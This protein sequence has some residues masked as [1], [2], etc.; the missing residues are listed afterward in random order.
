MHNRLSSINNYNNN[1]RDQYYDMYFM[2]ENMLLMAN[3]YV[4]FHSV[5]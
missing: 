3:I 5:Y 1:N 4:V 2:M